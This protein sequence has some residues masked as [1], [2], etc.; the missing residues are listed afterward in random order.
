M[1]MTLIYRA[2]ALLMFIFVAYDMYKE[3]APSLK[4]NACMV[5]V[6]LLLRIL[7]IK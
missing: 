2:I 4:V 1:V 5:L 7:M 6:P 3:D